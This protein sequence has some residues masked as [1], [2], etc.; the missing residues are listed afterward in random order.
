MLRSVH[1]QPSHI[2]DNLLCVSYI[3][4]GYGVSGTVGHDMTSQETNIMTNHYNWIVQIM[5]QS[6]VCVAWCVWLIHSFSTLTLCR[7]FYSCQPMKQQQEELHILITTCFT[8]WH[9]KRCLHTTHTCTTQMLTMPLLAAL[10]DDLISQ[11]NW[12]RTIS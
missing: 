8:A 1:L 6:S 9:V 7:L 10:F 4:S 11:Y 3:Y 2:W 12:Y 5:L